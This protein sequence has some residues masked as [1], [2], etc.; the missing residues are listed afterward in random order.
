MSRNDGPSSLVPAPGM[1]QKLSTT[2][3]SAPSHV[4]LFLLSLHT[5]D[6][7]PT[8]LSPTQSQLTRTTPCSGLYSDLN[9]HPHHP[10]LIISVSPPVRLPIC[11]LTPK[12]LHRSRPVISCS[13]T[14]VKVKVTQSCPTLQ[15]HGLQ[16]A[17]L[18]CSWNSP[19]KNTGVGCHF[20]LQGIFPTQGSNSGLPRCRQILYHLSHLHF[21]PI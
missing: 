19:G 20:L 6:V 21:T 13:P 7:S 3:H 10:I 4:D 2:P 5:R 12:I 17:R 11:S 16:P 14:L 1:K 9:H 15:R 18:L 8:L